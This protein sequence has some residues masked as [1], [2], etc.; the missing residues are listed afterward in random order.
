MDVDVVPFGT[1]L[2]SNALPITYTGL[3]YLRGAAPPL[4]ENNCGVV[5]E[6]R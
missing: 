5:L 3:N 6:S 2:A 4:R 1:L